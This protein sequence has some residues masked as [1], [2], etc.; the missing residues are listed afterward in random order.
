MEHPV[1][2]L[3]KM[4]DLADNMNM[5]GLSEP[6]DFELDRVKRYADYYKRINDKWNFLETL[7]ECFVDTMCAWND[8]YRQI[9]DGKDLNNYLLIIL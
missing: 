9:V 3:V 4:L 7:K 5:F 6:G 8:W 1:S 2:S